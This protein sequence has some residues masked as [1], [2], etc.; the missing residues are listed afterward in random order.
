MADDDLFV[1]DRFI[2]THDPHETQTRLNAGF[3]KVNILL[4]GL[5]CYFFYMDQFASEIIELQL[6]RLIYQIGIP[7]YVNA[8]RSRVRINEELI[9]F[10]YYITSISKVDRF[11]R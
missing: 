9:F 1:L 11:N 4:I 10:S 8:V 6:C 7:L 3:C 2:T 5:V